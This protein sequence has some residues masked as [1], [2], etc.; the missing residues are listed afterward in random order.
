MREAGSGPSE[1]P[2]RG[3]AV[4]PCRP[5]GVQDVSGVSQFTTCPRRQLLWLRGARS[6]PRPI[7]LTQTSPSLPTASSTLRPCVLCLLSLK[8]H[9]L[10]SLH[11]PSREASWVAPGLTALPV[12]R[13]PHP[14]SPRWSLGLMSRHT[15]HPLPTPCQKQEVLNHLRAHMGPPGGRLFVMQRRGPNL[16]PGGLRCLGLSLPEH[17]LRKPVIKAVC[18]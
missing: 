16:R 7:L 13:S 18:K 12:Q 14:S 17:A 2:S 6:A 11:T 3:W 1:P 9:V 15:R 4:T 5:G 8:Y 10:C